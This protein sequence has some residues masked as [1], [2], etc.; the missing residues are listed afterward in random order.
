MYSKFSKVFL[1]HL[2]IKSNSIHFD[3]G[4]GTIWTTENLLSALKIVFQDAVGQDIGWLY[5]SYKSQEREYSCYTYSK[6]RTSI[7]F[8]SM[9]VKSTESKGWIYNSSKSKVTMKLKSLEFDDPGTLLAFVL[10][11]SSNY[12][13]KKNE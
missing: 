5:N 7:F 3:R 1:H 11:H 13:T 2:I 6:S 10:R 8:V 4:S 12:D 9:T